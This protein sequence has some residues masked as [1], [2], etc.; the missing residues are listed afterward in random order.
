MTA[1]WLDY[2]FSFISNQAQFRVP[3]AIQAV[4]AV[5]CMSLVLVLPESPR[6]LAKQGRTEE[7]FATLQR[8]SVD[9]V[10]VAEAF[11]EIT[12]TLKE[13]Q[14]QLPRN[15]KGEVI[16]GMRACFTNGPGRYFYRVSL[17]VASQFMQSVLIGSSV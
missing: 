6:W 1:Y 14:E 3:I 8:L 5:V 13:E 10:G 16:S 17:G 15:K 11:E 9:G 7:S 12:E 4:F 2:G